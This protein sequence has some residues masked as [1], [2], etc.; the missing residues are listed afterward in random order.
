MMYNNQLCNQSTVPHCRVGGIPD[1]DYDHI[2][3]VTSLQHCYYIV[4]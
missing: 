2:L 4:G 3:T 1:G